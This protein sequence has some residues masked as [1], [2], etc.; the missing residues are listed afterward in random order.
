MPFFTTEMKNNEF[1]Y[2]VNFLKHVSKIVFLHFLKLFFFTFLFL[3]LLAFCALKNVSF[4]KI[5]YTGQWLS[6][7]LLLLV[8]CA[9]AFCQSVVKCW[10]RIS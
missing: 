10:G 5:F 7:V 4:K 9:F 3:P 1:F 8:R 6:S 2:F